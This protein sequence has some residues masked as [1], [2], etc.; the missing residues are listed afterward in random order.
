MFTFI[1]KFLPKLK[2]IVKPFVSV[3][4]LPL[5]KYA[6]LIHGTSYN[7][8]NYMYLLQINVFNKTNKLSY[9]RL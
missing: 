8:D 3:T 7:H 9:S 5:F 2:G 6:L 1:L 4:F